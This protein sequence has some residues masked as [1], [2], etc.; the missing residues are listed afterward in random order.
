[1][2]VWETTAIVSLAF[3]LSC[4]GNV[5]GEGTVGS[6]IPKY[7]FEEMLKHRNDAACPAKG[8]YTYGAFVKAASSFPLFGTEGQN[9]T[10]KRELAA[11]FAQTS[12][13]TT[14]GWET[15]P[16]GPS[17]Y[18]Y[19]Y[20]EEKDP[21][22]DFCDKSATQWPCAPGKRY[23]GRGPIQLSH[24]YNYGQAGKAI[25]EDLLNR[26]ELVSTDPVISFK[27]AI[28]FWMTPQ[29]PKPSCHAVMTGKWKPPKADEDAR[30]HPGFGVTTNI[31]NGAFECGKESKSSKDRIEYFKRYCK[32]L[33]VTTGEH[34]GCAKQKPFA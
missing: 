5:H 7:L 34:L 27:T 18:G 11:F 9:K 19:C 21:K 1:M 13:E 6:I 20:K 3:L 22:G 23:Y 12:H 25:H 30:R 15:A 28:W 4:V 17:F 24:N 10:R 32:L 33:G 14:A 2:A 31:I 26:P 8:F 29:S 16:D